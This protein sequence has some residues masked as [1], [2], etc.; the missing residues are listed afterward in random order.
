[1]GT[2]ENTKRDVCD[3]ISQAPNSPG[4]QSTYVNDNGTN[5]NSKNQKKGAYKLLW[6][7]QLQETGIGFQFGVEGR[8]RVLG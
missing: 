4:R 1:M 5:R 3:P 7:F 2:L 6:Y 8:G